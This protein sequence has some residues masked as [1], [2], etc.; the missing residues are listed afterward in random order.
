MATTSQDNEN[1]RTSGEPEEHLTMEQQ[2]P[3]YS[4]SYN[5]STPGEITENRRQAL[6]EQDEDMRGSDEDHA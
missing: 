1:E 5:E 3:S 4:S 2:G 6:Q